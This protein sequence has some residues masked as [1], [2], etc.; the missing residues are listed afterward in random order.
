M[1]APAMRLS[2]GAGAVAFDLWGG[3]PRS[4]TSGNDKVA[5]GSYKHD[6]GLGVKEI[7]PSEEAP[8]RGAPPMGARTDQELESDTAKSATESG[9]QDKIA[10]T[11]GDA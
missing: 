2:P 8:S 6:C 9:D 3:K 4:V 1:D 11:T 7:H 5:S 10:I